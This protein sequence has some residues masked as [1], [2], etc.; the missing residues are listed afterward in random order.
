MSLLFLFSDLFSLLEPE[1]V[2][3]SDGHPRFVCSRCGVKYKVISAL[4]AHVR[5]CG[6][7]A[8]C[9][10]CGFVCTQRRNLPAHI[11]THSN[12]KGSIKRR[13]PRR[14]KSFWP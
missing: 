3:G 4:K 13:K 7:G 8:Q 1:I 14:K 11:A 10:V 2:M 5:E 9:P 6:M 12:M